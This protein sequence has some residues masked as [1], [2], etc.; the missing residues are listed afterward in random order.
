VF[1]GSVKRPSRSRVL[2]PIL[3]LVLVLAP[4]TVQAQ[5]WHWETDTV[6]QLGKF[7][8]IAVDALGNVHVSYSDDHGSIKYAFRDAQS[9]KWFKMIVDAGD[10]YTDLALDSKGQPH[11]CYTFRNLKYAS[12]TD[13]KWVLQTIAPG[14]GEVSFS[15]AVAITPQGTPIVSWYKTRNLDNSPYDHLKCAILEDGTWL[16]HTVDFDI[17]TGK[18]HSLAV[19]AHGIP[20]LSYDAFV[21]GMLKYAQWDGKTWQVQTV[22]V[23]SRAADVNLGMGNSI[24]LTSNGQIDISF[25]DSNQLKFARWD[26]SR[27][28]VETIDSASGLGSWVGWHTSLALDVHGLPHISYEDAGSLKHAYWD[29]TRWHIEVIVPRGVDAYRY[30]SLAISKDD[31]I[32]ISYRDPMDGSLKVAVGRPSGQ[33]Q[34]A[35]TEK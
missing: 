6:D 30:S 35:A 22:D 14:T 18:W 26:G 4:L 9:S 33:V 3:L 19:D 32:Y 11:I 16:V 25:Q 13:N 27:W 8:S 28:K 15:C 7:T 34:R 21:N 1:G 23:R 5:T 12:F 31:A 10:A 17:Q 29:G 2:S 24:A 20:H